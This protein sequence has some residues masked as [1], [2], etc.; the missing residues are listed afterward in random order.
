[1]GLSCGL[2]ERR[3]GEVCVALGG[4]Y[5]AMTEQVANLLEGPLAAPPP[6]HER[7]RA[8]VAEVVPAEPPGDAGTLKDAGRRRMVVAVARLAVLRRALPN[9]PAKHVVVI[10]E[11]AALGGEDQPVRVLGR[12]PRQRIQPSTQPREA[13][14]E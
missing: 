9:V 13:S 8:R 1:M 11:A 10:A 5:R 2:F 12:V 14:P 4:R 3:V 6:T 7:A